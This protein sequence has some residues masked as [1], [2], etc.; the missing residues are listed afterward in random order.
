LFKNERTVGIA[1]VHYIEKEACHY[2]VYYFY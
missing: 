1:S 2:V